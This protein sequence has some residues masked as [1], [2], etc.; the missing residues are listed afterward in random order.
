M[1][2]PTERPRGIPWLEAEGRVGYTDKW[3]ASGIDN[4]TNTLAPRLARQPVST[5][6]VTS[7]LK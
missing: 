4:Q 1:G 5:C 3:I 2:A 7:G 6:A